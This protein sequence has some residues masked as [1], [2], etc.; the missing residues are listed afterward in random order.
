M[1]ITFAIT[2]H[3]EIT[4]AWVNTHLPGSYINYL[5]TISYYKYNLHIIKFNEYII[6]LYLSN[7]WNSITISHNNNYPIN[8]I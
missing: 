3:W 4:C 7:S 8:F 2:S 6:L 1:N 5:I